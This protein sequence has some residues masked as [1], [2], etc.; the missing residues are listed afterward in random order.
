MEILILSPTP[1]SPQNFGN[2]VR[3]NSVAA[4]LKSRGHNID[5]LLYPAEEDWRAGFPDS[6]WNQM[7]EDWRHV[8]IVPPT[9]PLHSS[10]IGEDHG[11][12]EWW[13]PSISSFLQ[14][15][16][17]LK[18]YD[19]FLVNYS[20]LSKALEFAPKSCLKVLDTHD[21]VS[22]RREVLNSLG[23]KPE[24][25]HTSQE[26]EAKA[27]VRADL[28]LAI[29]PEEELHFRRMGA[30]HVI[31]LGHAEPAKR[32]VARKD[33]KPLMVF[34]IF[35][36]RNNINVANILSFLT[37]ADAI[38]KKFLCP[39][40]LHIYGSV[41]DVLPD[42]KTYSYVTLKGQVQDQSQFYEAVDVVVVPMATS[43]GLKIKAAE[44]LSYGRP[45]VSHAHAFEGLP[46]RH[47]YH[48]LANMEDI[49]SA[50]IKLC[51]DP[52]LL[53]ALTIA[54]GRSNSVALAEY[55]HGLDKI[56][57]FR[58]HVLPN[59]VQFISLNDDSSSADIEIYLSLAQYLSYLGNVAV[60]V[61][62]ASEILEKHIRSVYKKFLIFFV[63]DIKSLD[64]G[65]FGDWLSRASIVAS[66]SIDSTKRWD[67]GGITFIYDMRG[68]VADATGPIRLTK[69][70]RML[71]ISATSEVGCSAG[72][73]VRGDVEIQRVSLPT[74]FWKSVASSEWRSLLASDITGAVTEEAVQASRDEVFND[75]GWAKLRRLLSD[76]EYVSSGVHVK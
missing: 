25:F 9:R 10:A 60:I 61:H 21:A 70:Q 47:P 38:F 46:A 3:I 41:C 67:R 73:I 65:F 57:E 64:S 15:I 18:R 40:E 44:A 37:A 62:N 16:F 58:N 74:N 26:E 7:S 28:V 43:T 50:V 76:R 63:D 27:L 5:L 42:L 52:G 23:I 72:Q 6:G 56:L 4:G 8:W 1:T 14:W 12:D 75:S 71:V 13:D 20:W 49:A 66:N 36:A 35:G 51:F 45:L 22:G 2:R 53:Y 19:L 24:F 59:I 32:L 33:Q 29:K 31:T 68:T 11:I 17:A 48:S 54:T 30:K 39:L 34:G 69:L 55:N